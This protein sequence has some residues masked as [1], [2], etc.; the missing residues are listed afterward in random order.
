M[1]WREAGF[2][3]ERKFGVYRHGGNVGWMK[4]LAEYPE[5][6]KMMAKVVLESCPE[7]TFTSIMV[8]K[9]LRQGVPPG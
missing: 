9:G 3:D 4:S 7:A 8:S 2:F 6:G 5:L 1:S